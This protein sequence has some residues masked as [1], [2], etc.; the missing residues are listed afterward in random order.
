MISR[1]APIVLAGGPAHPAPYRI[2]PSVLEPAIAQPDHAGMDDMADYAASMGRDALEGML[3]CE[4][5]E[6]TR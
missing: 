2:C 4:C 5:L 6:A 3:V 1:Y